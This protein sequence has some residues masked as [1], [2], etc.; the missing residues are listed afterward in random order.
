MNLAHPKKSGKKIGDI[1]KGETKTC[2]R[3]NSVVTFQDGVR[4]SNID[5]RVIPRDRCVRRATVR[6]LR[7]TPPVRYGSSNSLSMQ[8]RTLPLSNDFSVASMNFAQSSWLYGCREPAACNVP[9]I[10]GLGYVVEIISLLRLDEEAF[11]TKRVCASPAS[12]EG[13][14]SRPDKA[15]KLL[16]YRGIRASS[17]L[18]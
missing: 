8:N 17:S 4:D 6:S 11:K 9:I 12:A 13:E 15:R 14:K 1:D 10:Q 16:I 3:N 5:E 18:S 2:F 7:A